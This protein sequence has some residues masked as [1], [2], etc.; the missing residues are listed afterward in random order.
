M[1][2]ASGNL[3][4]FGFELHRNLFS[5]G[6]LSRLEEVSAVFQ[7][8]RQTSGGVRNIFSL[9]PDLL[10]IFKSETLLSLAA[11]IPKDKV[12]VS[13]G[14]FLDKRRDANWLVA[15][16]QDLFISVKSRSPAEGYS[17]WTSKMGK[18]YVQ[19]PA[20]V[21]EQSLWIRLN[22]DD[23]DAESGCLKVAPCSHRLGKINADE[24]GQVVAKFGELALPCTRGD[25]ILFKPLLLHASSKTTRPSQ[26]RVFQVLYSGFQFQNGLEWPY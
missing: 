8:T 6:E 4:Q 19:P 7:A 20:A 5:D 24:V 18:P 22:L 2:T 11:G 25:A 1:N 21:L 10:E 15:W 16:H 13:E 17:G 23:N 26:R 12:G 3:E 9:Q 14:L